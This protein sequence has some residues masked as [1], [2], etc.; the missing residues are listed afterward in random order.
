MNTTSTVQIKCEIAEGMF[1]GEF[2][3]TIHGVDGNV[4]LFVDEVLVSQDRR[5]LRVTQVGDANGHTRVLLPSE[6]F[7]TGS[8]WVD[9]SNDNVRPA[10]R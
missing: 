9:L 10:E 1:A 4:S 7:E 8:R 3:A 2:A 5:W 6:A